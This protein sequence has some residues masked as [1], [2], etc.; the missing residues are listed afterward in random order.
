DKSV[1]KQLRD[2]TYVF[3]LGRAA[4][5]QGLVT[6]ADG[7]PVPDANILVGTVANS[8]RRNGRTQNDGTFSVSGCPPDWQLVTASA[9][10]YAATTVEVN[11]G[12][13]PGP[14][15][16]V[17]K[18]GKTL[19]L[20]VVDAGGNPI[21]KAHVWYDC[22]NRISLGGNGPIPVQVEF[23]ATTD[24]QGLVVLTNAPDCEMK[25]TASAAGF[26]NAGDIRIRPDNEV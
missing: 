8:A 9:M 12:E 23:S 26:H 1:E 25:L 11:L 15:R 10:G 20:R 6:D 24:R 17:L 13:K 22:I 4:T 14:V 3:K 7:T 5:V 16:L 19:R 18:P 21:P 2:G